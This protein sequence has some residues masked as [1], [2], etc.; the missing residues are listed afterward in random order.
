[1]ISIIMAAYNAEKTIG[2]AVRS[3]LAQTMRDL[4]L[5]IVDDASTDGTAD[6][7]RAF[8]AED[9]RVRLLSNER[10]SGVSATRYHGLTEAAGE[11]IAILDSDDLWAPDKLES[12]M[13]LHERTGGELLFTGSAFI[14]ADGQEIPWVLHVPAKIGY[15][16]LLK[17]NLI[18]NSSVLVRKE[19]SRQ[20][21]SHG[22]AMH[23]DFA[24]WLRILKSG[25]TAYGIDRPLLTY[26]LSAG[27]KTSNKRKAARMNWNTYR[28]I[29]LGPA[30][31]AYYMAWYTFNGIRKYRSLGRARQAAQSEAE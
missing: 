2:A 10:N 21:Y 29:G 24:E 6:L 18:S 12:Q 7:A 25:V 14:D 28:Y 9:S 26:R 4:E 13:D 15:R 20:Y 16:Q 19:L 22:D 31:A 11:W 30:E 5:L 8:A 1:M 3:A 27:S 23:E 17:Q